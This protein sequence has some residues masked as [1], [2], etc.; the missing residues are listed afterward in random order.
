M[1][2]GAVCSTCGAVSIC[3]RWGCQQ[4][5]PRPVRAVNARPLKHFRG[6]ES[7]LHFR[8][9]IRLSSREL[10]EEVGIGNGLQYSG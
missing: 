8:K 1:G 4:G 6:E 5:L 9:T 7:D 10:I 2:H 3:F